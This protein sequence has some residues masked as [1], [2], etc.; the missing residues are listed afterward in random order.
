RGGSETM[1]ETMTTI[2]HATDQQQSWDSELLADF[3]RRVTDATSEVRRLQGREAEAKAAW[4]DSR[5]AR[6]KAQLELQEWIEAD[7]QGAVS[8][9]EFAG[10][11]QQRTR[12]VHD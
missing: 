7:D 9:L 1:P 10:Q 8:D 6:K 2:D 11:V 3:R 12:A 4:K 5:K